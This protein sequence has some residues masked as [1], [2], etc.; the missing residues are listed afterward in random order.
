MLTAEP[1]AEDVKATRAL[2]TQAVTPAKYKK[3]LVCMDVI[4]FLELELPTPEPILGEWLVE[5]SLTLLHAW[6]GTGKTWCV[7]SIAY[8]IASGLY[9]LKWKAKKPRRVLL[10]DGEMQAASMQARLAHVAQ[11]F[12]GEPAPGYLSVITPDVQQDRG[13]P[14]IS[15][16]E[17][18]FDLDDAIDQVKP[19]VIIID[20]LSCLA[21]SGRENESESWL[22]VADW[23]LRM[24]REGRS[25][26]FVHH[27]G[28]N[29]QQR[30]TSKRED[31]LDVVI[32]LKR[33]ADS[34]ASSGAHFEMH[35]EKARHT[36]GDD[37]DPVEAKLITAPKGTLE[38][39]FKD[40]ADGRNDRIKAMQD[41]GMSYS[42]IAQELG[43]AKSTVCRV[44]KGATK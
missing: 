23:A 10:V 12:D 20:N 28:K 41:D 34:D 37:V 14:D 13:M 24:R 44:L 33:T 4:D 26:L 21:R 40:A 38:W 6:R 27:S 39:S 7:L 25:V 35:F 17:G 1:M 29:G 19:E 30:G 42:E 32:A 9:F 18:Q 43:I 16:L 3:P 31:I 8:A 11:M 36:K 22:V 5:R 2:V 15:T